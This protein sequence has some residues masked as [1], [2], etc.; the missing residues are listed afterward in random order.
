M[1]EKQIKNQSDDWSWFLCF[2]SFSFCSWLAQFT[3][4]AVQWREKY[5]RRSWSHKRIADLFLAFNLSHHFLK[6]GHLSRFREKPQRLPCFHCRFVVV[7]PNV[8]SFPHGSCSPTHLFL[9]QNFRTLPQNC[10]SVT[11]QKPQHFTNQDIQCR[12]RCTWCTSVN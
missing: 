5:L 7:N 12:I 10:H 9:S 6:W 8:D 11:T 2:S 1:F 3:L 4:A